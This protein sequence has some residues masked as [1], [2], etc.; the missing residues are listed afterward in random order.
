L[1]PGD[2]L[3][4][5]IVV[6]QFEVRGGDIANPAV[7]TSGSPQCVQTLERVVTA[8][9]PWTATVPTLYPQ[10]GA[11]SLGDWNQAVDSYLHPVE[12][13]F[14]N[15]GSFTRPYVSADARN[16]SVSFPTTAYVK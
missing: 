2:A 12:V 13:N 5:D 10:E 8:A 1:Y 15:L 9:V 14:A 4:T 3:A 7:C 16:G 6:D 11:T